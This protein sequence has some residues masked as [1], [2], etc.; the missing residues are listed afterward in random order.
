MFYNENVKFSARCPNNDIG[1]KEWYGE[2]RTK[3]RKG[4]RCRVSDVMAV[5]DCNELC[6]KSRCAVA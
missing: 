5:E 2:L 4:R 1:V 3:V 6:G